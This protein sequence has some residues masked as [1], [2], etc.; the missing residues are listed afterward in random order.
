[1]KTILDLNAL[2][3]RPT[4][5]LIAR[6]LLVCETRVRKEADETGWISSES[7][8]EIVTQEV[9]KV[10]EEA[11]V[12]YL[13]TNIIAVMNVKSIATNVFGQPI[14]ACLGEF[15]MSIKDAVF[16]T[17]FAAANVNIMAESGERDP[18]SNLFTK[19]DFMR[20]AELA[21]DY[22]QLHHK[23]YLKS[24]GSHPPHDN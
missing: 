18:N 20:I 5:T 10:A 15:D 22:M 7:L 3:S 1:M 12:A 13:V 6:L 9:K 11:E 21:Y 16:A 14:R 4:S 24:T 23:S 8:E 2:H 19:T 17:I